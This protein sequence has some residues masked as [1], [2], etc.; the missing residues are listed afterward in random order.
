AAFP[1]MHTPALWAHCVWARLS[2]P[3]S[4][5]ERPMVRVS[6]DRGILRL[7]ICI[8]PTVRRKPAGP[9]RSWIVA[10]IRSRASWTIWFDR[11]ILDNARRG[12]RGIG[13]GLLLAILPSMASATELSHAQRQVDPVIDFAMDFRDAILKKDWAWLKTVTRENDDIR[14]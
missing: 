5:S 1:V 12:A 7:P 6:T 9:R 10:S 11:Q 13:C 2:K 14:N 4:R 3:A 8:T